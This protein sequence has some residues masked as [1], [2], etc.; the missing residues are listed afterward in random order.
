MHPAVGLPAPEALKQSAPYK[1]GWGKSYGPQRH[2]VYQNA[3][4]PEPPFTVTGRFLTGMKTDCQAVMYW[5]GA[6][7]QSVGIALHF[8][9]MVYA[10]RRESSATT[11]SIRSK[12]KYLADNAWH[13]FGI[14][15]QRSGPVHLFIDGQLSNEGWM[16]DDLPT[17]LTPNPVSTIMDLCALSGE[18]RDLSIYN[19]DI[20]EHMFPW[21]AAEY[22]EPK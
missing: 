12:G 20:D 14:V 1:F 11:E 18:V 15:R 7:G 5:S 16:H 4:L 17:R 10:E 22:V 13:H 9:D 21:L 8:G 3:A 2:I 19:Y 6:A